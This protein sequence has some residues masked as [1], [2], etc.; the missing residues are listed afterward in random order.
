MQPHS[1]GLWEGTEWSREQCL[2][3]SGS[4]HSILKNGIHKSFYGIISLYQPIETL[5]HIHS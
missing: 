4:G 2:G 1:E 5:L 3:T